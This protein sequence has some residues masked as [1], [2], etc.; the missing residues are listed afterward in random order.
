MFAFELIQLFHKRKGRWVIALCLILI[1]SF[2]IKNSSLF[3][4]L[5]IWDFIISPLTH[6]VNCLIIIPSIFLFIISDIIMIDINDQYIGLVITRTKSRIEWLISKISVLF[7][8]AF[9]FTLI[10]I[11]IYLIVGIGSGMSFNNSW[12][13]HSL[14]NVNIS[15]FV[16]LLMISTVYV[17]TLTA[18]G[19]LIMVIS[20]F[21]YNSIIAWML[22]VIIS[23][24]SYVSWHSYK[25]I[26]KWMPT[27]QMMFLSQF[28]N[29]LIANIEDFTLYWSYA[30][31]ILLFM[32]ALL[33]AWFRIRHMK[34]TKSD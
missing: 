25:G 31:N 17:F 14:F 22:G 33:L 34:L 4:P 18:V 23:T 20:L 29:K 24:L 15:P 2:I 8:A 1:S 12:N 27:G 9:L 28:P 6:Q 3:E 21:T 26:L 13:S 19:T 7:M 10:C 32:S 11:V 16:I 5:T 30:Y